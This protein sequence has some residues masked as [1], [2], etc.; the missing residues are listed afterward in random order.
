MPPCG[1]ICCLLE[2]KLPVR[3][4]KIVKLL[5]KEQLFRYT[6]NKGSGTSVP[7]IQ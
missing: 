6:E 4:Q 1:I 5:D 2:G 7:I 3:Q